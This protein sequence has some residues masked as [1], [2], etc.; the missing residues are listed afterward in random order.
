MVSSS[1]A[2]LSSRFFSPFH[3]PSLSPQIEIY[4]SNIFHVRDTLKILSFP[5]RKY[6]KEDRPSERGKNLFCV[7]NRA[8]TFPCCAFGI[9][10]SEKFEGPRELFSLISTSYDFLHRANIVVRKNAGIPLLRFIVTDKCNLN[11]WITLAI[12]RAQLLPFVKFLCVRIVDTSNGSAV[13]SILFIA[14]FLASGV[15]CLRSISIS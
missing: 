13:I 15:S 4:W 6:A 12:S 9:D 2:L 14:L 11:C 7:A 1:G 5:R 8:L 3:L 10:C